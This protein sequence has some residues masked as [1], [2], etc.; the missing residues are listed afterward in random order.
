MANPKITDNINV[1]MDKIQKILNY[2]KEKVQ[3]LINQKELRKYF[4]EILPEN[5]NFFLI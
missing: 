2:E 1:I 3:P 5:Y 4:V